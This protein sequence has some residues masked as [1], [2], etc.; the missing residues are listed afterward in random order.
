MVD[1]DIAI[2]V[3][4]EDQIVAAENILNPSYIDFT[5]NLLASFLVCECSDW[6][7]YISPALR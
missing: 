3:F 5:A 2:K 7:I 4:A 1:R 6:K